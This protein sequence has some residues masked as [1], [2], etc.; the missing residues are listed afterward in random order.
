MY[1][2]KMKVLED[3]KER[4]MNVG[5]V[6]DPEIAAEIARRWVKD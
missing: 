6:K 2:D 1:D 3:L 5:H 4:I